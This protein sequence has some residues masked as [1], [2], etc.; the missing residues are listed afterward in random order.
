VVEQGLSDMCQNLQKC[1]S[2]YFRL[3]EIMLIG[4]RSALYPGD[5]GYSY[6]HL[7][8]DRYPVIHSWQSI[9]QRII[10]QI[11]SNNLSLSCD[12]HRYIV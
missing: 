12:N 3:H 2:P 8:K 10:G 4:L 9:D 11:G 1:A 6:E 5:I 7:D